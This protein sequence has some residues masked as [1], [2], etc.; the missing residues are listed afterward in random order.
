MVRVRLQVFGRVQG[1][2]FRYAC[3]R[4]AVS[5][6][7]AGWVRNCPDE[8]VEIVAEGSEAAVRALSCWCRHGPPHASVSRVVTAPEPAREALASFQIE[9]DGYGFT[10]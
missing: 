2:G 6:G 1:V 5:L 10:E 3:W 4:E 8:S 7:L 9:D